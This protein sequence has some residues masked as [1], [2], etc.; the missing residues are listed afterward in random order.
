MVVYDHAVPFAL[1][2]RDLL[3]IP[4]VTA[5]AVREVL[6]RAGPVVLITK[7]ENQQLCEVGL[8]RV[9]PKAKDGDHL[10]RYRAIGIEPVPNPRFVP[11]DD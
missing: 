1:L 5:D 8:G 9:M 10:A 11:A 4:D 6:R 7:A 2:Q 3:A